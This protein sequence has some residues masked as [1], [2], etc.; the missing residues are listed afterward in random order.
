MGE[1]SDVESGS[2]REGRKDNNRSEIKPR[3][4]EGLCRV[5]C[6]EVDAHAVLCR[7]VRC[8]EFGY[9]H[10]PYKILPNTQAVQCP[11]FYD[12]AYPGRYKVDTRLA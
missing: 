9:V 4:K 1:M 11:P 8:S 2:G 3:G 6:G 10:T 7:P 5:T 12:S